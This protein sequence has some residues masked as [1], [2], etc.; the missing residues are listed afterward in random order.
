MQSGLTFLLNGPMGNGPAGQM[1]RGGH[2]GGGFLFGGLMS[3]L[4]TVVIVLA[5]L[6]VTRNWSSIKGYMQRT[7]SS[8]QSSTASSA[9]AQAPLE[10]L[11]TR[12]A[13]GEINREEY[14]SIRRDLVGEP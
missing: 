11:Q 14:E 6:W 12:Y 10:I 3:V 4:W 5:V 2:M 9:T 7:A 13:K 1:M 8:L